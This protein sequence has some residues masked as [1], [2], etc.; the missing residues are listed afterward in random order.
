[1]LAKKKH[2]MHSILP[3]GGF[4]LLGSLALFVSAGC[5]K[6]NDMKI[7]LVIDCELQSPEEVDEVK[8]SITASETEN[9]KVCKPANKTFAMG[10]N[11]EFPLIVYYVVGSRYSEWFAA[12]VIF[13]HDG[14]PLYTREVIRPVTEVKTQE[15]HVTFESSCI[16]KSCEPSQQCISGVCEDV[17]Q[18]SPFDNPD[19]IDMDVTCL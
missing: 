19:I 14:T 7:R 8:I 6:D 15:I 3:S 5:E 2:K 11:Y 4:F 10:S 9:G 18:P 17:R 12:R 1:M 13:F 16:D